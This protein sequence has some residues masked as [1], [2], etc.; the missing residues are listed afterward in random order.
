MRWQSLLAL[1]GAFALVAAGAPEP[2]AANKELEKLQG[3]W[4]EMSCVDD[5]SEVSAELLQGRKAVIEGDKMT[6]KHKG[7]VIGQSA[8]KLDPTR[9]PKEIDVTPLSGPEKGRVL[10]GIYSRDGDT[11]KACFA[12]P[13][14]DRPTGFSSKAG[15]GRALLVYKKAKP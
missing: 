7:E 3:T 14:E 2:K 10:R 12:R 13:G 9:S 4:E 5:G 8:I 15:S 11:L 1:L 6:E